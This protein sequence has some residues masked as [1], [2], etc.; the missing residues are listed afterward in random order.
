M[1]DNFFQI[2]LHINIVSSFKYSL[3]IPI[4]NLVNA[5]CCCLVQLQCVSGENGTSKNGAGN[6]GTNGKVS[7][8]GPF[9]ILGFAVGLGKFSI[10]VIFLPTF[11]FIL[12]LP[13]PLLLA[14]FYLNSCNISDNVNSFLLRIL[15]N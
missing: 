12:L 11:P 1:L 2:N 4:H 10:S 15:T 13:V 5:Q 6:Y 3:K 14:P 8:N 9:S 7:K